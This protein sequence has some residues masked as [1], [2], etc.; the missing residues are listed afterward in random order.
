MTLARSNSAR[1]IFFRFGLEETSREDSFVRIRQK[2]RMGINLTALS[3]RLK[4]IAEGDRYKDGR[5]LEDSAV[6]DDFLED[7]TK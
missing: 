7:F 3:D 5:K 4:L 1:M 2:F 6:G